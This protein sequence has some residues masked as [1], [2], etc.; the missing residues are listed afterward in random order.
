MHAK[1]ILRQCTDTWMISY[2]N[3]LLVYNSDKYI[4]AS[5]GLSSYMRNDMWDRISTFE[6][7]ST[8]EWKCFGWKQSHKPS[9]AVCHDIFCQNAEQRLWVKSWT[10]NKTL[11]AMLEVGLP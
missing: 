2:S 11:A 4:F 5:K 6:N 1:A 10:L 9:M 7:F 3:W 8:K